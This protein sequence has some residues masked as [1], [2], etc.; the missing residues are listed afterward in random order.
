MKENKMEE[1][2]IYSSTNKMEV[3]Y[4]CSILK[5]K[6]ISFI[7][8]TEGA[9]EYLAIATG[10]LFNNTIEIFVSERD[11]EKAKEIINS[12]NCENQDSKI[13]GIPDELKDLSDEEEKEMNEKAEKT[14]GCLRLF[15]LLFVFCPILAFIIAAIVLE[16]LY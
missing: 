10:N 11:Y 2:L 7:K 8:K 9:G 16:I 6:N 3:D 13:I 1:K 4:I 14:K 15:I 5:E 12:I